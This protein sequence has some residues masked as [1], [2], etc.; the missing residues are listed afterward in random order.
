VDYTEL[1]ALVKGSNETLEEI[2]KQLGVLSDPAAL[3]TIVPALSA[4]AGV[5]DQGTPPQ[6]FMQ[7]QILARQT[8]M[9]LQDALRSK[10]TSQLHMLFGMQLAKQGQGIPFEAW[11][12]S[13]G[14]QAAVYDAFH[15]QQG[16]QLIDPGII[17]QVL[18]AIDTGGA[19]AL[20]RQD[21]E[22]FLYELYVR[23]FTAFERFVK[24]PANGLTHTYNQITAFGGA[25]FMAE[26]GTV[27]DSQNTY[28]RKTTNVAIVA[29]RRGLSLKSQFAVAAGGMSYNPMDL[30]LQGG[31]RAISK[32]MQDQIFSGQSS[33]SGGSASTEDGEYQVDGFDGLRLI[34]NTSRAINVD[35]LAG[36]PEDIKH[37]LDLVVAATTQAGGPNPSI[38][39]ANPLTKITFDEQQDAKTRIIVPNQVDI[40]VGVRAQEINV[41]TGSVPFGLVKG[42]SISNY[43]TLN[44][45]GSFSGGENVRDIY[46]LDESTVSLPYLGSEGPTVLDI[47]IGISG[48]LTH[49]F[50][51]FGMWGFAVKALPFSNKLR[52][53]SA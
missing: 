53:K 5:I 15:N 19:A 51:L 14:M 23:E 31:L 44:A 47:P 18:N 17:P 42:N 48:Q 20:I 38:L 16:S 52:V 33:N 36:T 41:L 49:L 34:L 8:K 45:D 27:T 35:P 2:N 1:L 6:S 32:R 29:T 25:S 21:L 4:T 9:A 46:A 7:R 26:L 43:T 30:E 12:A 37:A 10:S 22:P 40:G 28:E 50:I 11:A 24:E 13:G 39:W 3:T